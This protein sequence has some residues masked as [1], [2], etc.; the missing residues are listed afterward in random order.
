MH[1]SFVSNQFSSL[2]EQS[3]FN[4]AAPTWERK[5]EKRISKDNKKLVKERIGSLC[6]TDYSLFYH[7]YAAFNRYPSINVTLRKKN[8]HLSSQRL[9]SKLITVIVKFPGFILYT[10]R[11]LMIIT[12]SFEKELNF[13]EI[14]LLVVMFTISTIN[15]HTLNTS[16]ISQN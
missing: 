11:G 13:I 10:L 6:T 2:K 3:I 5:K 1:K 8:A 15:Q 9:V 12:N 16:Y 7:W 14:R 4:L